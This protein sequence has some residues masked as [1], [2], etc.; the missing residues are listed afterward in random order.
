MKDKLEKILD[1]KAPELNNPGTYVL[2]YNRFNTYL[3]LIFS[4]LNK[5]GFIKCHVE[6][7]HTT[8]LKRL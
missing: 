7:V 1:F 6:L 5:I 3:V 8:K 4:D 2:T